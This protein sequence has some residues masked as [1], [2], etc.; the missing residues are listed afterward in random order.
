MADYPVTG[1]DAD[2]L[3][4]MMA[5]NVEARLLAMRE[6]AFESGGPDPAGVV[7]MLA[8]PPLTPGG[9]PGPVGRSRD[10]RRAGG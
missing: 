8:P 3:P 4:G 6:E 9:D 7:E 5:D 10:G 1:D 2:D